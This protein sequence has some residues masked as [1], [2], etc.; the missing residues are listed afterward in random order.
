[1]TFLDKIEVAFADTKEWLIKEFGDHM[2][3][4]NALGD[5]KVRVLEHTAEHFGEEVSAD[6]PKDAPASTVIDLSNS[7]T[8]NKAS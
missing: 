6:A 1:M 5:L 2:S 8:D 4:H 7:S 3:V